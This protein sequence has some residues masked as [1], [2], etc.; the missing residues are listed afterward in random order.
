MAAYVKIKTGF[1][2][3]QRLSIL[4]DQGDMMLSR[5]LLFE[6]SDSCSMFYVQEATR[7][8]STDMVE[9]FRLSLNM[10]VRLQR[11]VGSASPFQRN[12]A[13]LRLRWQVII[14]LGQDCATTIGLSCFDCLAYA[15][16]VFCKD[17]RLGY[18]DILISDKSRA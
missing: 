3:S 8:T 14:S 10:L 6:S 11:E 4:A 15:G 9:S 13:A 16:I 17:D 18:V 7:T 12:L 2:S 1:A 5:G